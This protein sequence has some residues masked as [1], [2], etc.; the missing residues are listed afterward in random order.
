MKIVFMGTPEFAAPV[1]EKLIERGHEIGFVVTQ[2]DRKGNRGAVIFS[3]VKE[4]AVAHGIKVLQPERLK[5][6]EEAKSAIRGFAPDAMIVV[7]YGQ[8]LKS[9]V[10]IIPRYGCFNVHASILPELRGASP[11]QHA[12][13][14][15][16]DR[17]GVTVMRMAEGI[18][19]GDIIDFKTTKIGKKNLTELSAELSQMG[20]DLM[21]D[22]LER[23]EDGEVRYTPQDESRATYCGMIGKQDGLIDFTRTAKSIECKIRAFDPWP[24]A[25]SDLTEANGKVTR[26]KFW[27]ADVVDHSE[28]DPGEITK[29]DKTGIYISTGDGTLVLKELQVPGKKRVKAADYL[30]GHDLTGARFGSKEE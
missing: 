26:V 22:T 30:L 7:A 24:G 11:I 18:D 12:I 17:T 27:S 2:P 23:I 1:L 28:G 5:N 20:A 25:F 8:I 9:D 10:L 15:G 21:A 29:A 14:N 19:D 6:D 16:M 13:L 4:V 3:P